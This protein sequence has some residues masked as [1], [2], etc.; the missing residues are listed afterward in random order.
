V[1]RPI[2]PVGDISYVYS[3]RKAWEGA[4]YG[5]AVLIVVCSGFWP[6]FK[7]LLLLL[8]WFA[9][10]SVR[11]RGQILGWTNR[12]GR[13]CL[14]DVF[15]VCLLVTAVDFHM[16]NNTTHIITESRVAIC[17]FAIAGISTLVQGEWIMRRH[18]QAAEAEALALGDGADEVVSVME[19]PEDRDRERGHVGDCNTLGYR[20]QA[21]VASG[22][23]RVLSNHPSRALVRPVLA[24][25]ALVLIAMGC[26]A[27]G[28]H[29]EVTD[30]SNGVETKS[31]K[32]FSIASMGVGVAQ[33]VQS[34][35]GFL[36]AVY[37]LF[38][39][40]VPLACGLCLALVCCFPAITRARALQQ[41]AL[42]LSSFAMLDVFLV[43]AFAIVG[44]YGHL[45]TAFG[46]WVLGVGHLS[47]RCDG[48][49]FNL[50]RGLL[51]GAR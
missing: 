12:L 25:Q 48:K 51:S 33:R 16:I 40:V 31:S 43:A 14:V 32:T 42:A 34:E 23:E 2:G 4:A 22:V 7:N 1:Y 24:V 9:P 3:V 38:V 44:E 27:P 20:R 39:V 49:Y 15:A 47:A 5:I 41:A 26:F 50:L 21:G 11:C 28:I 10:M 6:Y 46:S 45:I 8:C 17:T 36:A 29:F 37:I 35:S 13:F 19:E 18:T 30:N